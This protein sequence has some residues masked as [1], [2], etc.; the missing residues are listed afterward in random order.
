MAKCNETIYL[1]AEYKVISKSPMIQKQYNNKPKF[2]LVDT[3]DVVFG[4]KWLGKYPKARDFDRRPIVVNFLA[5]MS[6]QGIENFKN[7]TIVFGKLYETIAPFG[8]SELFL[9]RE[10]E[11]QHSVGEFQNLL[12][13][14]KIKIKK[15]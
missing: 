11:M 4:K 10:L 9:W 7:E 2:L 15:L 12:K 3:A 5:R 13:K 8:I 1:N 6:A 14:N